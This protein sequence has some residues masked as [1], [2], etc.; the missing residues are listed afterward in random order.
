MEKSINVR[1]EINKLEVGGSPLVLPKSK[2]KVSG[3]RA[4]AGGLTI[5]TGKKFNVNGTDEFVIVVT[6]IS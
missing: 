3:V 5:D 4:A 6:R 2:Y 1:G